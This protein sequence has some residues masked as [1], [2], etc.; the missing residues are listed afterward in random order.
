M[1]KEGEKGGMPEGGKSAPRR[2]KTEE[3]KG[4]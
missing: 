1:G 2:K 3:G 4:R